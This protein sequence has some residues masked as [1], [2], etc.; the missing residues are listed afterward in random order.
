MWV[1]EPIRPQLP[2]LVELLDCMPEELRRQ[3]CQGF[4]KGSHDI[5]V[6]EGET[7]LQNAEVVG[8]SVGLFKGP[9]RADDPQCGQSQS[10]VFGN[11]QLNILTNASSTNRTKKCS[12]WGKADLRCRM[13]SIS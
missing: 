13:P 10:Y 12:I 11:L 1:Q 2:L 8:I 4:S 3:V 5:G 7:C 6:H 9:G